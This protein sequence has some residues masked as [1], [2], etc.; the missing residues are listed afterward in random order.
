MEV[1][2][3]STLFSLMDFS[4]LGGRDGGH[5]LKTLLVYVNHCV[6]LVYLPLLSGRSV[7]PTFTNV[8][9]RR[10]GRAAAGLLKGRD[11]MKIQGSVRAQASRESPFFLWANNIGGS[12]CPTLRPI[13]FRLHRRRFK[14]SANGHNASSTMSQKL[15]YGRCP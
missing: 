15:S 4:A 8:P 11:E 9:V 5:P 6:L 2:R 7:Y 10:T 1:E 3:S 14:A 12:Q 13:P